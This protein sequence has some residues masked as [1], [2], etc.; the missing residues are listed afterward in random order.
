MLTNAY[1][2]AAAVLAFVSFSLGG[3]PASEMGK[4][5]GMWQIRAFYTED[6]T[7]GERHDVY[8]SHPTGTMHVWPDGHFNASVQSIE[9]TRVAN[10]IENIAYSATL[11]AVRAIF[12]G[13]T[14]RIDGGSIFVHVTHV[15]HEGPAGTDAFDMTWNE[16]RTTFEET[17]SFRLVK[18]LNGPDEMIITTMPLANPNG[19]GNTIKGQVVWERLQD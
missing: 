8:G 4:V 5:A 6:I 10:A 16:G 17:R 7:T 3:A 19:T 14:Y 1:K 18:A 9:P 15:R 13:G 11:G 2:V 12:Y